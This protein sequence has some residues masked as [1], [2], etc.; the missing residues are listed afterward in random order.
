MHNSFTPHCAS[1]TLIP[2]INQ[3]TKMYRFSVV[4]FLCALVGVLFSC[5]GEDDPY[6]DE[7]SGIDWPAMDPNRYHWNGISN[8][9][10]ETWNWRLVL[11]DAGASFEITMG[12]FNPGADDPQTRGAFVCL[13]GNMDGEPIY[14]T[15]SIK[16]FDASNQ[17]IDV[18]I[19]EDRG[20]Q[21]VLRVAIP[22]DTPV[23]VDLQVDVEKQ[24]DSTMGIL[25][26][27][28]LLPFNWHVGA[29]LARASGMITV[30]GN[31][32]DFSN[33]PII[34]DHF[35]GTDFPGPTTR[36]LAS[37]FADPADSFAFLAQD[38]LLGPLTL[39]DVNIVLLHGGQMYEFRSID[40]NV[41]ARS[42]LDEGQGL[43]VQATRGNVRIEVLVLGV[44][45]G[46]LEGF[47]FDESGLSRGGRIYHNATL[48]IDIFTKDEQSVIWRRQDSMLSTSAQAAFGVSSRYQDIP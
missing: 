38:L 31:L 24:W 39:D 14:R 32:Y 48:Q 45:E 10:F 34:E 25:T 20:T 12:I 19:G 21:R 47:V 4:L 17:T 3:G 27:I 35:W 36:I 23:A 6:D 42:W 29:L 44:D 7:E 9:F 40:L 1:V 5:D 18:R 46:A 13:S 2:V 15:T 28:P 41:S 30:G 8:P 37:D 33:A 26:N 16:D 22:G 43:H 11:P